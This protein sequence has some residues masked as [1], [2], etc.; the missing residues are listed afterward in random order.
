MCAMP[1]LPPTAS[2][3]SNRPSAQEPDILDALGQLLPLSAVRALVPSRH[4]GKS[5]HGA[6]LTRW[7]L[8]GVRG[9]DGSR[10][11]LRAVK[12]GGAWLTTREWVAQFVG[13]T[14]ASNEPGGAPTLTLGASPLPS[15]PRAPLSTARRRAV[16][17]TQA[18]LT[19]LGMGA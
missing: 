19:R 2:P 6:T 9:R 5:L 17:R 1:T 16:E 8:S 11:R 14:M 15:K 18:E 10:V 3:S 13:A 4:A 7:I 12:L